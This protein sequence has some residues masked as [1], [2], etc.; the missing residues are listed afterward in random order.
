MMRGWRHCDGVAEHDPLALLG[1]GFD[2]AALQ[3]LAEQAGVV[4]PDFQ[5]VGMRNKG[6]WTRSSR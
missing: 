3:A 5:P 6:G 2:H 1:T 4:T